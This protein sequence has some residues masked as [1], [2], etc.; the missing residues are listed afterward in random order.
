[1]RQ[2]VLS[3]RWPVGY[4]LPS[5]TALQNQ[6]KISRSTIRHALRNLEVEG[7]IERMPGRGT[8]VAP[9]PE[10]NSLHRPIAFM[11]TDFERPMQRQLLSGAEG[12]T[13]AAGYPIFFCNSDSDPAEER[14]ML[15]QFQNDN[16]AGILLWPSIAS[17]QSDYLAEL[18]NQ[19]VPPITMMDRTFDHI[20]CDYVT[21]HNY[22]GGCSAVEHLVELGHEHIAFLSCNILG[23]RPIGERYRGY[24]DAMLRA[25]LKPS[26]AWIIGE[27]D[28]E[29][30]SEFA[31]EAYSENG[32]PL[33]DE[34]AGLLNENKQ[35]AT[36]IFAINDNVAL[37]TLKA[38]HNIGV[39][40]PDELSIVG[41]DDLD[42]V[43]YLP[44]P[45]TTVA[46]DY[47]AI[48]KEAAKLLIERIEGCYDGP[49]R[50][51]QLPTQLRAR[52]TTSVASRTVTQGLND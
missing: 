23:L 31:L 36:A 35:R 19:R 22:Q 16:V 1:M 17:G 26:E 37:L 11:V 52:A 13:R 24:Q 47:Y 9:L 39:R 29:I 30:H 50:V 7:L 34:I 48:G 4:R 2:L 8:F 25:G 32:S 41:Y 45:L 18:T 14:R 27:P 12:V 44:T 10:R 43:S 33:V 6:L 21:S 40:V 51:A 28:M 15:E 46:Q 5:E 42:I 49:P 38:A 3:N 20:E